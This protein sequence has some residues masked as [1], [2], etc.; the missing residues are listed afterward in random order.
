MLS[1]FIAI[2]SVLL[3]V[4]PAFASV[5]SWTWRGCSDSVPYPTSAQ[6]NDL[7]IE[8][9]ENAITKIKAA[10]RTADGRGPLGP[11]VYCPELLYDFD[12]I[13]AQLITQLET[14]IVEGHRIDDDDEPVVDT[15]DEETAEERMAIMSCEELDD[16]ITEILRQI[17]DWHLHHPD[18][19]CTG[20]C[21]TLASM[22]ELAIASQSARCVHHPTTAGWPEPTTL[23]CE[24]LASWGDRAIYHLAEIIAS[25]GGASPT[26]AQSQDLAMATK[27]KADIDVEIAARCTVEDDPWGDEDPGTGGGGIPPHPFGRP[28]APVSAA[29]RQLIPKYKVIVKRDSTYILPDTAS[30]LLDPSAVPP[31]N[32]SFPGSVTS[33]P[34]HSLHT[35]I[36]DPFRRWTMRMWFAHGWPM[37]M[38]LGSTVPAMPFHPPWRSK[39]PQ[40]QFGYF[41]FTSLN[42]NHLA[43]NLHLFYDIFREMNHLRG[44]LSSHDPEDYFNILN[45]QG[46]DRARTGGTFRGALLE[47]CS[48]LI[49]ISEF[50]P[51]RFVGDPDYLLEREI[52]ADPMDPLIPFDEGMDR[53]RVLSVFDDSRDHK[54]NKWYRSEIVFKRFNTIDH[55]FPEDLRPGN[56]RFP[57][58]VEELIRPTLDMKEEHGN[59]PGPTIQIAKR[60]YDYAFE[61]P[62]ADDVVDI[63]ARYTGYFAPE[64]EDYSA[65][66]SPLLE[67]LF[68][69]LYI[70][71]FANTSIEEYHKLLSLHGTMP[72][73]PLFPSTEYINFFDSPPFR[74]SPSLHPYTSMWVNGVDNPVGATMDDLHAL[75][76]EYRSLI[77][78]SYYKS[79]Y[80]HTNL[81]A[82]PGRASWVPMHIA[83]SFNFPE[84]MVGMLGAT[85]WDFVRDRTQML[86]S[87]PPGS[88]ISI[89]Y[90]PIVNLANDTQITSQFFKTSNPIFVEAT[91][92][93]QLSLD[94]LA[95]LAANAPFYDPDYEDVSEYESTNIH[96]METPADLDM[97]VE[98]TW[99]FQEWFKLYCV[100]SNDLVED[101]AWDTFFDKF[102]EEAPRILFE[103]ETWVPN[104]EIAP[105]TRTHLP[106]QHQNSIPIGGVPIYDPAAGGR[107]RILRVPTSTDWE[108]CF[109]NGYLYETLSQIYGDLN[110]Q[111][112]TSGGPSFRTY[113]EVMDG[114]LAPADAL[115]YRIEK[116]VPLAPAGELPPGAYPGQVLQNFILPATLV[117]DGFSHIDAQVR[118]G[119]EY[120]LQLYGYYIVYGNEYWYEDVEQPDP[121]GNTRW[122]DDVIVDLGFP[123]YMFEGPWDAPP[124]ERERIFPTMT[125]TDI[126][127][128]IHWER[129]VSEFKT[130]LMEQFIERGALVERGLPGIAIDYASSAYS[131]DDLILAALVANRDEVARIVAANPA[132]LGGWLPLDPFDPNWGGPLGPITPGHAEWMDMP[133]E[134]AELLFDGSGLI[135]PFGLSLEEMSPTGMLEVVDRA[136]HRTYVKFGEMMS[137][138]GDLGLTRDDV[139]AILLELEYDNAISRDDAEAII[140]Q[141]Q[142]RWAARHFAAYEEARAAR[143]EEFPGDQPMKDPSA[144]TKYHVAVNNRPHIVLIETNI[145]S[146]RKGA[147][148]VKILDKPPV[149][150]NVDYVPYRSVKNKILV[151][152]NSGVGQYVDKPKIIN[153]EDVDIYTD[154]VVD[155]GITQD[156]LNG[157]VPTSR[158]IDL[159]G[160][161][162]EQFDILFK[163]DDFPELFEIYRIDFPPRR[164]L[165]FTNGKKITL[166]NTARLGE[167]DEGTWRDKIIVSSNSFVDDILPNKK[168]W[169]TSRVVDVHDNVSN[170]T[171]VIQLEMVD[172]GNSIY[173]AIQEYIFPKIKDNYT[174]SMKKY[175]KIA[176][177]QIQTNLHDEVVGTPPFEEGG[178]NFFNRG[179]GQLGMHTERSVWSKAYKL[180]ITSKLTG[181]KIDIN[182]KFKQNRPRKKDL[183]G[184]PELDEE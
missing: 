133:P 175:L 85:T 128:Q 183:S 12:I 91:T 66:L 135:A 137:T 65:D 180:R 140:M 126:S 129:S 13:L 170:P 58:M 105:S 176:P 120:E 169:Y 10:S 51:E 7:S 3:L 42:P 57:N 164:Y 132:R 147:T 84:G 110:F 87:G 61:I 150:P 37:P 157:R 19:D 178:V 75:A 146:T 8:Q 165:D 90:D 115:F 74:F 62:L 43:V 28:V 109:R 154:M 117:K 111:I 127:I 59:P 96:A 179:L 69:N 5:W 67:P 26:A 136:K 98:R 46:G 177:S 24:E 94:E 103:T 83:T 2:I 82:F 38:A 68:P 167:E 70:I 161:N 64:F 86:S 15:D 162:I 77:F 23:S 181:K 142:T 159:I 143:E 54:I 163:N 114:K 33:M 22:L 45:R 174:K 60:H 130:E 18:E 30:T 50:G 73:F 141:G 158:D 21:V 48:P 153:P 11:A 1:L 182:F 113:K 71:D 184:L 40:S 144:P 173:P 138:S 116:R 25:L 49:Y 104:R 172:T 20:G 39:G 131:L 14:L 16:L 88:G 106:K 121:L 89:K 155:Q 97:K 6:I 166:D 55:T 92:S 160:S 122:P 17:A 32:N 145:F 119:A 152:L 52:V 27:Y 81:E 9:I 102:P 78:S 47:G 118:Y 56:Y 29:D 41:P 134:I 112:G 100:P 123:P 44:S 31:I 4:L 80:N 34:R 139:F 79:L 125:P 148:R 107:P 101:D 99:D 156:F 124:E 171:G 168:Y 108:S 149:S 36:S 35:Y 63:V 151:Q 72:R 76:N 53:V 95:T 93:G